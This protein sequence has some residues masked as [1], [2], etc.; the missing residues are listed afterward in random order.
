MVRKTV[1]MIGVL[2]LAVMA[3]WSVHA[4]PIYN[5]GVD[6]GFGPGGNPPRPTDSG[7]YVWHNPGSDT[8]SI[9]WTG[10]DND[11]TPGMCGFQN[12]GLNGGTNGD[13]DCDVWSW[14]GSILLSN[15]VGTVTEVQFESSDQ[16]LVQVDFVG[17]A[18]ISWGA[19]AGGAWDGLDFD[20]VVPGLNVIGFALGGG[21]YDAIL[22]A[23]SPEDDNVPGMNIFIGADY[24]VPNVLR[25]QFPGGHEA[26]RFEINVPAPAG[27][28][29]LGLGMLM[30]GLLARAARARGLF[31][32]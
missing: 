32:A 15:G 2:A 18:T 30:A 19:I 8:W 20:I 6:A 25:E 1:S 4:T 29:I 28:G 31:P 3:S 16:S 27:L 5:G 26:Q 22:P 17:Q 12:G 10:N 14:F 21:L 23:F 11:M 9:R 7:Y 13:G 24:N